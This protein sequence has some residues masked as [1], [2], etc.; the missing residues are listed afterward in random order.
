MSGI[1]DLVGFLNETKHHIKT[2]YHG[3]IA[4]DEV[5]IRGTVIPRIERF[6][7]LGSII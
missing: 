6:R 7:Y 2:K 1:K 4:D 5:A 3:T